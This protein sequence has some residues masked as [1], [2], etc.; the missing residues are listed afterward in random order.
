M[1]VRGGSFG[2][3]RCRCPAVAVP[4]KEIGPYGRRSAATWPVGVWFF[5][6]KVISQAQSA[7]GSRERP[8]PRVEHKAYYCACV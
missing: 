6:L 5:F 1:S 2:G 4:W 3:C 8:G 7:A